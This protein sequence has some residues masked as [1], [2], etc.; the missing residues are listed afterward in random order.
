MRGGSSVGKNV[1]TQEEEKE[2]SG[3][4]EATWGEIYL[5]RGRRWG[6]IG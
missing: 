4:K 2:I 6:S 1:A 5:V 3:M